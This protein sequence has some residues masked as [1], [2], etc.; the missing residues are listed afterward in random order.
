MCLHRLLRLILSLS[1]SPTPNIYYFIS[2]EF[3]FILFLFFSFSNGCRLFANSVPS[4]TL[5]RRRKRWGWRRGK[6]G[7]SYRILL[8]SQASLTSE[9]LRVRHLREKSAPFADGVFDFRIL[10]DSPRG[11]RGGGRK[12]ERERERERERKKEK[13][14][15][16]KRKRRRRRV[17]S[18]TV[19][20]SYLE[21]SFTSNNR[22]EEMGNEGEMCNLRFSK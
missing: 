11:G 1:L 7:D 16:R 17:L 20:T 10:G 12:R 22:E 9:F 19:W 4:Q 6:E 21:L 14:T 3:F 15:K 5:L 18:E 13:R 2:F 8:D